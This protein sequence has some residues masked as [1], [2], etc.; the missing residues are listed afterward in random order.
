MRCIYCESSFKLT[1][2]TKNKNVCSACDGTVDDLSIDDEELSVEVEILRNPS[3]K[4][5]PKFFD[6][7]YEDYYE[8]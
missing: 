8:D 2:F 1:K 4:T 3:G 6:E 5:Q 7:S